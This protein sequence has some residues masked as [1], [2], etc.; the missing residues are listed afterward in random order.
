[1]STELKPG[2]LAGLEERHAEALRQAGVDTVEK[3]AEMEPETTASRTGLSADDLR[4]FKA[5][6]T[7]LTHP[8]PAP[9]P[10]A[11]RRSLTTAWVMLA[12]V[13]ITVIAVLYAGRV[14]AGARA[15]LADQE[16]KLAVATAR[17]AEIAQAHV[18]AAASNLARGNW[19][20]AQ[21]NLDEAGREVTFLEEIAPR[22]FAGTMR[23]VRSSLG[24]AQDT[25]S[26]K[27]RAA[28]ERVGDLNDALAEV[29]AAK[30]G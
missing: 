9:A 5:Q 18:N 16:Q 1:M 28:P 4:R 2:A 25:V 26:A 22:R 7:A 27:D 23:Q 20:L 13:I 15:Q 17:T 3:L 29:A 8:A 19:G 12:L 21:Q 11:P 24:R 6:A 10:A 30:G 14:R